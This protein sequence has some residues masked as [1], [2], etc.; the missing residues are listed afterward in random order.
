MTVRDI[1]TM[2]ALT[3]HPET[4]LAV[5]A[6]LMRDEDYGTLPVTDR[7]GRLVGIIT[8]RDICLT[9]AGTNRNALNIAVNEAMTS[10][11]VSVSADD[12]AHAALAS[13]KRARVRRLPVRNEA[14]HLAGIVSIED[15]VLRG[16]ERG[17]VDAGEIVST[18]RAL[19]VRVPVEATPASEFTPG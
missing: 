13:M 3:C 6:R 14:G 16:I 19:Y 12:S 7:K 18:L 15:I 5:A 1:M 8:D 11:V 9:L 2:P 4:S 10:N 17:G